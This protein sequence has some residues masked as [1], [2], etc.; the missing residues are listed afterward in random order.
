MKKYVLEDGFEAIEASQNEFGK[1]HTIYKLG[2][3]N[4]WFPMNMQSC[5]NLYAGFENPYWMN[6][7]GIRIGGAL[8]EPNWFGLYFVISPFEDE[9]KLL[10][11]LLKL[12]KKYLIQKNQIAYGIHHQSVPFLKTKNR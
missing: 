9:Y 2:T 8:I 4:V 12:V 5:M 3:S 6:L 7:N 10:K 1:Y 11:Q